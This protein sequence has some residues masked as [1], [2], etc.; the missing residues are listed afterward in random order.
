VKKR[1]PHSIETFTLG[2]W[3]LARHYHSRAEA[4][5]ALSYW[6]GRS[7]H[8]MRVVPTPEGYGF[9]GPDGTFIKQPLSKAA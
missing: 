5:R 1:I 9:T 4:R 7:D 8:E 3:V 6:Q 2:V